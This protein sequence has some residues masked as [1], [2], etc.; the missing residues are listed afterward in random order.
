MNTLCPGALILIHH[1]DLGNGVSLR[2]S[3][4][5]QERFACWGLPEKHSEKTSATSIHACFH[6]FSSLLLRKGREIIQNTRVLVITGSC[7]CLCALFLSRSSNSSQSRSLQMFKA[8]NVKIPV[9]PLGGT[10]VRML[11]LPVCEENHRELSRAG[12]GQ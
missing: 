9:P 5:S 7:S 6:S 4:H 11:Q 10:P 1:H 2:V 3:G 8:G 12:L